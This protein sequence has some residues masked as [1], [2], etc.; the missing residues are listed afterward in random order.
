MT[1]IL[2]FDLAHSQPRAQQ[3]PSTAADAS[4]DR[5][6]LSRLARPLTT[7]ALFIGAAALGIL[8]VDVL[9][10][11]ISQGKEQAL[12]LVGNLRIWFRMAPTW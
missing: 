4:T 12:E 5:T 11:V 1:Q 9:D 3:Q 7:A 8:A 2:N 6:G 10:F